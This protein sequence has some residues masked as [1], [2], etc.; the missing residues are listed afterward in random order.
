MKPYNPNDW[1]W[2]V[3][4]NASQVYSSKAAI[5][6]YVPVAD[7]V[8]L[9]WIADGTLPTQID[10]EANLG[11]VLAPIMLRPIPQGILDSYLDE[12]MKQIVLQPE[13]KLWLDLYKDVMHPTPDETQVRA[14]MRSVL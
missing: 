11:T 3:G 14:R 1:Y 12:Q 6:N 10:T 2:I 8:Y 5:R 4:G 13:F 7:T 9:A